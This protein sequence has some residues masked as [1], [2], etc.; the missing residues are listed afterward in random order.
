MKLLWS[1]G[2]KSVVLLAETPYEVAFAE[3]FLDGM[4]YS[5]YATTYKHTAASLK[6]GDA[7]K[8]LIV[9]AKYTIIPDE[10]SKK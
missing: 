9:A 1:E 5:R 4:T 6:S 3:I 2:K 7:T 8:G 10:E